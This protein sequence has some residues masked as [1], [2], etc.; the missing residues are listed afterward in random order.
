MNG[1]QGLTPEMLQDIW[2]NYGH[3][4]SSLSG[5]DTE[6]V[7]PSKEGYAEAW[8]RVAHELENPPSEKYQFIEQ[9]HF[10]TQASHS[11]SELEDSLFQEG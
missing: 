5:I 7:A 2:T 10:L 6:V 3:S 9:N 8:N 11:P 4:E 1:D